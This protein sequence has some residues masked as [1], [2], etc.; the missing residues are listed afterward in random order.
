MSK[1]TTSINTNSGID[2]TGVRCNSNKVYF[3]MDVLPILRQNCAISG[4][5]GAG[6]YEEGVNMENY[7][8]I[9]STGKVK[10]GNPGESELYEVIT[11]SKQNDVMPPPSMAKLTTAQ[12]ATISK[13][14]QQGAKN[15]TCNPN[16]GLPAAC[17]TEGVTYSGVVKKIIDKQCIGCHKSTNISGGVRLDN[18]DYLLASVN[19]GD[20]LASIQWAQGY[21]KMPYNGS[22]LD[23][24]S[25][26]KI[27]KWIDEGAKNN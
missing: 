24:C 14:I 27:K 8:K 9:I 1:D 4:C 18:Y 6:T 12:I 7:Q 16:Y 22:K 11:T 3:E 25:I 17:S 2:L 13:W 10:A 19:K 21:V 20:F 23:T 5:H 15:E 26:N